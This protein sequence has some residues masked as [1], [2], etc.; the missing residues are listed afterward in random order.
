MA[1]FHQQNKQAL[2]SGLLDFGWLL[3]GDI[4][5]VLKPR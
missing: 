4:S 1:I 2:V 3:K 5:P